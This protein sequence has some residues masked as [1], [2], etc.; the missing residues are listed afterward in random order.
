MD[1][2]RGSN[3]GMSEDEKRKNAKIMTRTLVPAYLP[4]GTRVGLFA[5]GADGKLG[6]VG[7]A[8]TVRADAG[9]AI[10]ADSAR[11]ARVIAD[12]PDVHDHLA[13]SL[14]VFYATV[15]AECGIVKNGN[16]PYR[17]LRTM[18]SAGAPLTQLID[19]RKQFMRDEPLWEAPGSVAARARAVTSAPPPAAP[20]PAPASSAPASSPPPGGAPS[21]RLSTAEYNQLVHALASAKVSVDQL[22]HIVDRCLHRVLALTSAADAT[23]FS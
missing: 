6:R 8:G 20:P 17:T 15:L 5:R 3:G 7:R 12:A 16:P 13:S 9:I 19:V 10:D 18:D 14:Y 22:A 21:V 23:F 11:A 2:Q 4:P 1:S